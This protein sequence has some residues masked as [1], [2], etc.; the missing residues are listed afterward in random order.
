MPFAV[1]LSEATPGAKLGAGSCQ[2]I[3]EVLQPWFAFV[4][5]SSFIR[6]YCAMHKILD[7]IVRRGIYFG[8]WQASRIEYG[9][10]I[11]QQSGRGIYDGYEG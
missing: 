8:R 3:N 2:S 10:Q 9:R 11:Y 4:A 7:F 1:A 5:H 6:M